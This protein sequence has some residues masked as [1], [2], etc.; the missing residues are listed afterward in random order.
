M[1]A[2][3]PANFT[4]LPAVNGGCYVAV[5]ENRNWEDAG[6]RCRSL[7]KDAHLVAINDAAEQSAIEGMLGALDSM[8][9]RII[10]YSFFIYICPC[11]CYFNLVVMTCLVVLVSVC[12]CACVCAC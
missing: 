4:Y 3:C 2:D 11:F 5:N 1:H 7:H 9:P 12:V 8:Y 10:Y 6:T